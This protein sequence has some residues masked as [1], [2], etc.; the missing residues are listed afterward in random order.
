LGLVSRATSLSIS[1]F[2]FQFFTS[3][4]CGQAAAALESAESVGKIF[5]LPLRS[6]GQTREPFL[7]ADEEKEQDEG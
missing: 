7:Y 2:L 3:F 4:K 6:D 5:Q 1:D